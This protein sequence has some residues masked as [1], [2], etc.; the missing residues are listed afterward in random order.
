MDFN[1]CSAGV[2]YDIAWTSSVY[3]GLTR[4]KYAFYPHA[5]FIGCLVSILWFAVGYSL[6]F[7]EG[8]S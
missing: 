4:S 5:M 2:V 6:A 8:N 3:G 1:L 7:G